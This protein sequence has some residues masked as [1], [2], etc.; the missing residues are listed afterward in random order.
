MLLTITQRAYI[1][2]CASAIR[3][4]AIRPDGGTDE[5]ADDDRELVRQAISRQLVAGWPFYMQ[6][7]VD[8]GRVRTAG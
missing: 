5:A 2:I 6:E 1:S 3:A 8:A 7:I 4:V